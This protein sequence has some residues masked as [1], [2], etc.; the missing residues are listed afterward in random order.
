MDSW[1]PP[2]PGWGR[3]GYTRV[4]PPELLMHL[5]VINLDLYYLLVLHN[6]SMTLLVDAVVACIKLLTNLMTLVRH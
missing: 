2:V 5:N 3:Q 1:N 6:P 4:R